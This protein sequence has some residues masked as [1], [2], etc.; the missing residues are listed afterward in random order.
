LI[1]AIDITATTL[2]MA[3]IDK[4]GTM[5]GRVML[6]PDKE[7]DREYIY[8]ASD[9]HGEVFFKSRAVR[10]MQFK[11]IRNYNHDFSINEAST[12]YKKSNHPIYHL[13]DILAE[14]DQLNPVQKN[15][16]MPMP[17]EELYDVQRDPYEVMNLAADPEYA[18]PL[19]EMRSALAAWQART[20]D[21]GLVEDSPALVQ[22]FVEYGEKSAA[23][24]GEKTKE[25]RQYV[26]DAIDRTHK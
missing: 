16:V 11:Y 18:G 20:T 14:R 1:S 22:H 26:L 7:A 25:L 2:S 8:A 19:A 3:G 4:P 5:Q 13:I 23:S 9:R 10:S 15:L 24:R 6:G 17:E 12:A 21:W